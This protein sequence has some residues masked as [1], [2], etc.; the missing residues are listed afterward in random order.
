MFVSGFKVANRSAPIELSWDE[1]CLVVHQR[2]DQVVSSSGLADP[3]TANLR[4]AE[5][6]AAL[7][8][9]DHM[10]LREAAE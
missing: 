7:T 3:A 1:I 5:L 4:R 2:A 9:R 6:Q 10:V 8:I